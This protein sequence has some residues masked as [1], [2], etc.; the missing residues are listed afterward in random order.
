MGRILGIDYG[1]KRT[2]LAVTDPLQIIAS[3]L[4]TVPTDTLFDFLTNYIVAENVESVV[5]GDPSPDD[6]EETD[7]TKAIDEFCKKL[8]EKF[9]E[10]PIHRQDERYTS[11]MAR[12]ALVQGGFKKKEREKKERTD[13]LSAVFILRAY[14]ENS[15]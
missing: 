14:M 2:G 10:L 1:L 13:E 12:Q 11:Q 3:P 4:K 15:H 9:S 8:K 5:V 6:G 7:S